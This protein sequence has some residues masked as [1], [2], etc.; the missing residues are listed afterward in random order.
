MLKPSDVPPFPYRLLVAFAAARPHETDP[1]DC[2]WC[3]RTAIESAAYWL[4][5]EPYMPWSRVLKHLRQL[6]S[7]GL[8]DHAGST[9][10]MRR[11]TPSGRQRLW[12]LAREYPLI[13]RDLRHRCCGMDTRSCSNCLG[14]F[15]HAER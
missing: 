11:L 13:E 4:A 9:S 15:D 12:E 8:V 2:H 6:V 3:D 5:D 1:T 10:S 7:E 14:E